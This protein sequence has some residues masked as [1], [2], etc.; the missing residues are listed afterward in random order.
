[1]TEIKAQISIAHDGCGY[2]ENS[3][4]NIDLAALACTRC[5]QVFPCECYPN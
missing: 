4:D 5:E 2:F 3:V 1:M